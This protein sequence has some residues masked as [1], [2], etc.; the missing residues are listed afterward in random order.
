MKIGMVLLA[1]GF[2]RRF[3]SN[4]L[5]YKIDGKPM[6]LIALEQLRLAQEELTAE[7]SL[8]CRLAVVTQYET[9]IE[10]AEQMTAETVRNP[11][12]EEGIASS[13]KLG[14]RNF[15]DTDACLFSVADQPWLTGK[16]ITDLVKLFLKSGKG[17][18]CAAEKGEPG[19]PCI[20]SRKYY[21]ELRKLSGD[22]GGKRILRQHL[23]DA[24]LLE[25]GESRELT[26][27][28]FRSGT[29]REEKRLQT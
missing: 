8:S 6:Y 15:W 11:H 17:M 4:K 19:N 29:L 28:D 7:T 13:L 20:F 21:P 25:I 9:I 10:T 23:E 26:D 24:A 2:S 3:G 5:L 1:A 14:L 27:V 12:P 16:T 18:A 22:K